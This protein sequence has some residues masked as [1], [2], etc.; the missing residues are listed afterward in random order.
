MTV[1]LHVFQVIF[2]HFYN[3]KAPN[4]QCTLFSDRN[5]INRANISV[6]VSKNVSATKSVV[7]LETDARIVA[8]GMNELG[9][10]DINGE[11]SSN[12]IPPNLKT[13]SKD[14]KRLFLK[15]LAA[16]VVDRYILGSEKIALLLE[17]VHMAESEEKSNA[18]CGRYKCR[19]P[20]CGNYTSS[21]KQTMKRDDMFNYQSSFL[22]I[23]I[24]VKNVLDAISE[25]DGAR[26]V[27][28][29]KFML[30]Y[31]RHDGTA[32]RKYA[33]EALYLQCQVNALL[34]PRAAHRLTWNRF[35]KSK[36]GLGRNIPLDLALEHFSRIIKIL[37]KKLGANGL[38]QKAL[39]RHCKVLTLNKQLLDNFDEMCNVRKRSGKHV[40]QSRR[41]DLVKV[42]QNLVENKAFEFTNGRT[43]KHFTD[44]KSS[45]L[46]DFS[47][48]EMFKW[49]N[50]HK[51]KVY[52]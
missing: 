24:L 25:G 45:L 7:L 33:V 26:V 50:E 42:V 34:S 46:E 22:E 8:A 16:S 9:I 37:M 10:D 36:F 39:D 1:Y 21:H 38:S 20:G 49:V 19:F 52:T 28:C 5:F 23:A 43:Y 30:Q 48:S 13:A 51:K 35:L 3:T 47:V 44:I 32:S 11:P 15:S 27:R 40:R 2:N 29:R 12:T 31:L 41:N 4:D 6:D 14:D 18:D 17:K